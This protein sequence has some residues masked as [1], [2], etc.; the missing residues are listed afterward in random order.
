[1]VWRRDESGFRTN[2]IKASA[3]QRSTR[4][5]VKNKKPDQEVNLR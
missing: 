1:M 4:K 5:S 3:N 2:Q